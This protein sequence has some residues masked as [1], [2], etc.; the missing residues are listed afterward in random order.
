MATEGVIWLS[1]V[2]YLAH[3]AQPAIP[4]AI[5]VARVSFF[6]LRSDFVPSYDQKLFMM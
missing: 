2:T 1:D 6:M 5:N 3:V 4:P